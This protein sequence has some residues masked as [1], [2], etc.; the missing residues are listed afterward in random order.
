[1]HTV[2]P[3]WKF[4]EKV[5]YKWLFI[6]S[7]YHH[8][9]YYIRKQ[10]HWLKIVLNKKTKTLLLQI[11]WRSNFNSIMLHIRRCSLLS[12]LKAWAFS[13]SQS[14]SFLPV[15][16]LFKFC[17]CVITSRSNENHSGISYHYQDT[18]RQKSTLF[19]CQRICH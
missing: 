18:L 2:K 6:G 16:W 7:C 9:Y 12:Q 17:S 1:M 4:M 8:Y 19:E 3:F 14:N 10:F 11:A 15:H 5:L 13:I